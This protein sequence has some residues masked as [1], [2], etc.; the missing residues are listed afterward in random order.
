[1]VHCIFCTDPAARERDVQGEEWELRTWIQS[2][3]WAVDLWNQTPQ[4]VAS[5]TQC[6]K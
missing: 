3:A 1:M 5:V 4:W 2:H 6:L